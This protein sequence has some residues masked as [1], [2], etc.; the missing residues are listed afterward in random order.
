MPTTC[1]RRKRSTAV[2]FDGATRMHLETGDCLL[3]GRPTVATVDCADQ[4]GASV[5]ISCAP[6]ANT[7][8]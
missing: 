1:T 6:R 5:R 2:E 3:A 8:D 4:T 7:S